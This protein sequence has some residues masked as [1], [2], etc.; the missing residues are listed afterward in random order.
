M[1][2]SNCVYKQER[3]QPIILH[4]FSKVKCCDE[5][6]QIACSVR[7]RNICRFKRY[8]FFSTVNLFQCYWK[9]KI[10]ET[11]KQKINFIFKFSTSQFEFI[12]F[13]WKNLG[14]TF[15]TVMFNVFVNVTNVKCYV[16]DVVIH[17]ATDE[18]HIK[19]LEN[20]FE[21]LLKHGLRM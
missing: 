20:V 6:R 15:Q 8:S 3:W 17:S 21:L 13:G 14:A 11:C 7:R 5:K 16:D 10:D 12:P 1:E 2:I 19:H 18:S 9:I 4:R